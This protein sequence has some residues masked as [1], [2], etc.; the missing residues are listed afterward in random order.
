MELRNKNLKII[1]I[2]GFSLFFAGLFMWLAL[3]DLDFNKVKYSLSQV[4]YFWILVSVLVG[5]LA[6]VF[7]AIR[8][9]LLLNP[10]GYK[11]KYSNAFWTIAFGY[12]MNLT[13]PRSGEVVRATALFGVEKV[14]IEKSFATIIIERIVDFCFLL[15][16]LFLTFVFNKD[17]LASFVENISQYSSGEKERSKIEAFLVGFGISDIQQFYFGLKITVL[18]LFVLGIIIVFL[19][20][21]QKLFDFIKG[22]LSG[23]LS[24][25]EM[26]DRGKF[27]L[28]SI[29][30]WLCY[31]LS[32]YFFC[33]SLK[34]T[35]GFGVN[36]TLLIITAGTFGMMVPTSGG[37]G[38]FHIAVKL[39]IAGVFV[40][41]GEN[42]SRGEEIGLTYAI[43]SHTT[44]VLSMLV[45]GLISIPILLKRKID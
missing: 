40:F 7:R 32:A 28:Y 41:L 29:G 33:L 18:A 10:M 25:F 26:R 13:I 5:V 42:Q 11:I 17:V 2:F 43:V 3:G 16:F 20:Y 4:N 1:L 35:S 19:K 22:L 44:Q 36:E 38:S 8:W 31:F 27:I 45:L 14:P 34:E 37:A 39:A 6:Y 30:I 9:D 15:L 21:R 12:M 24:V 23:L